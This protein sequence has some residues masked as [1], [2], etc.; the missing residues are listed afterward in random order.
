MFRPIKNSASVAHVLLVSIFNAG[1][2][3]VKLLQ[4]Q[5]KLAKIGKLTYSVSQYVCDTSVSLHENSRQVIGP[6]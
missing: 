1:I 2:S 3:N 6:I 5:Q 4:K